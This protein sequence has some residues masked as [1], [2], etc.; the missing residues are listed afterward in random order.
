MLS[1][2]NNVLSGIL[3]SVG[4]DMHEPAG[5]VMNLGVVLDR[6]LSL[7]THVSRID[8]SGSLRTV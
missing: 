4:D 5:T 6:S 1:S 7:N 8:H 2:P 3:V